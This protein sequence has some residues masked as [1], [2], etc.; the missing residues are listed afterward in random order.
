MQ[1]VAVSEDRR[2]ILRELEHHF[3]AI[4]SDS[5]GRDVERRQNHVVN[6]YGAAFW[7]LLARHCEERS[8]DARAALGRRTNLERRGARCR[9][10]LFLE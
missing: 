8:H 7:L 4:G 3:D 9:V 6:R 2:N 1:L 10:S 5:V